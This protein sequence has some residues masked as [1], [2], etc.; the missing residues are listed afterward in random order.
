MDGR[1]DDK[2][3]TIPKIIHYC[4]FGRGQ[5]SA[6]MQSCIASWESLKRDYQFICWDES[7]FDIHSSQFTEEAYKQKKWAFVSDYVRLI[8]LYEYGG[9]YLDTDMMF[10]K[11]FHHLLEK[12][13][14]VLCM[15]DSGLIA[16]SFI[17]SV[18]QH[19]FIRQMLA[20]Y[21]E[22]QVSL[23]KNYKMI[24]VNN[25]YFQKILTEQYGLNQLNKQQLLNDGITIFPDDFFHVKSYMTGMIHLTENSCMIHYMAATWVSLHKKI[26]I[27]L[28]KKIFIPFIGEERYRWLKGKLKK[29]VGGK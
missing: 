20:Q 23:G 15:Q 3:S 4:W 21:N 25:F 17:A 11:P 14:L 10:L 26:G 28:R 12:H 27:Y 24:D 6:L 1:G 9:V 22:G 2:M 5:K 18:P 13:Q 29:V 19:D 16:T 7:N 8:A